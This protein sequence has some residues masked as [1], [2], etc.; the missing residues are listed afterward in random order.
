MIPA[1]TRLLDTQQL[2]IERVMA[3]FFAFG[4]DTILMYFHVERNEDSRISADGQT[5]LLE[6]LNFRMTKPES[7]QR[8]SQIDN[9]Q[10]TS[11]KW[12]WRSDCPRS[13][14]WQR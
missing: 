6:V 1:R 3:D 14:Y 13:Q 9:Q 10:K 7:H 5:V 2:Y 12:G 4:W 11:T 8:H